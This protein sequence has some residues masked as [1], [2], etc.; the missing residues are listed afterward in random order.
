MRSIF[1][2]SLD[3]LR[4]LGILFDLVM[5]TSN[6]W[7][8]FSCRVCKDFQDEAA[9]KSL[10]NSS[11]FSRFSCGSVVWSPYNVHRLSLKGCKIEVFVQMRVS[12]SLRPE[13]VNISISML[14]L[15]MFVMS[16]FC[17]KKR[18]W[19]IFALIFSSFHFWR[20]FWHLYIIF[21]SFFLCISF[22]NK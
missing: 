21:Y 6:K 14:N 13:F 15:H 11:V 22:R 7:L 4:A 1:V 18:S 16:L 5:S 8:C 19:D 17:L 2:F 12:T 20:S 3:Q 9:M 10:Y